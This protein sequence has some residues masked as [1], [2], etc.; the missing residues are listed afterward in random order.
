VKFEIKPSG[1]EGTEQ[2]KALLG[3]T[4]LITNVNLPNRGQAAGLPAGA[5]VETNAVFSKNA[6]RPLFAGR[7]PATVN[8]FVSK[9]AEN[10]INIVEAGIKKDAG[11]AFGVFLN[12]SLMTL[13]VGDAEKLFSEML[14][15]TKKY[16][17]GWQT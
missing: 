9:H 17:D 3:M 5:I 16:L 11:L 15:N 8:S 6:V 4:E 1:E 14:E 10:Q 2:I 12:D 7:L 13:N